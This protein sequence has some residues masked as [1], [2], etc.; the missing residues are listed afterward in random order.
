VFFRH[1][2]DIDVHIDVQVGLVSY[3]I[4]HTDGKPSYDINCDV[5]KMKSWINNIM[6]C[7]ISECCWFGR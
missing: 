2:A 1:I 3:S 6:V 4:D 5:T 7:F